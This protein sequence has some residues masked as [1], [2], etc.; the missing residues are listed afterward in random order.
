VKKSYIEKY[1]KGWGLPA[2]DLFRQIKG[3]FFGEIMKLIDTHFR[4]FAHGGLEGTV[5]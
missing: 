5:L 4:M 1:T 3:V 2:E